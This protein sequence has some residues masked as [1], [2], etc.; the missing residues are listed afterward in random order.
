MGLRPLE[1]AASRLTRSMRLI[2][3]LGALTYTVFT[4]FSPYKPVHLK[5]KAEP[6]IYP[7]GCPKLTYQFGPGA[8]INP[9]EKSCLPEYYRFDRTKGV[10]VGLIYFSKNDDYF[11]INN[12]LFRIDCY[13]RYSDGADDCAIRSEM[14]DVF[15]Q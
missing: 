1:N 15:Y 11:R 9:I 5:I 2:F 8:K 14:N 12:G 10:E 13:K 4:I 7:A 6:Y 3:I